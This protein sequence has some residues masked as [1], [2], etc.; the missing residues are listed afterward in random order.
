MVSGNVRL[1]SFSI[2]PRQLGSVFFNHTTLLDSF[3][4]QVTYSQTLYTELHSSQFIKIPSV[5][6][7]VYLPIHIRQFLYSC[8]YPACIMTLRIPFCVRGMRMTRGV[9]IKKTAN[10]DIRM[11]LNY[12]NTLDRL[13]GRLIDSKLA[14]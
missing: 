13:K 8:V 11:S 5:Y 12:S 7:A 4:T 6:N 10:G 3:V 14:K 1:V 2:P 9:V